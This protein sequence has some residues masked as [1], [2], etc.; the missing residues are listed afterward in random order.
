MSQGKV[1]ETNWTINQGYYFSLELELLYQD[2]ASSGA[3]A[4]TKQ[5]LIAI[6]LMQSCAE[7]QVEMTGKIMR[8]Q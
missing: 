2:L 4:I 5:E 3:V 1:K 7:R 8:S 6:L